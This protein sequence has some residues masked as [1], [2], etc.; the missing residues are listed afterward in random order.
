MKNILF[1]IVLLVG[2]VSE[3]QR[4][5]GSTTYGRRENRLLID[6][7]GG[8]PSDTIR[9]PTTP[10]NLQIYSWVAIK[11]GVG[12]RWDTTLL[13]WVAFSSA[14]SPTQLCNGFTTRIS[15]T[16][17]SGFDFAASEGSYN[18][19]CIPYNS[20]SATFRL[21]T[22]DDNYDRYDVFYADGTGV[23]VLKGIA[24]ELATIPSLEAGQLFIAWVRIPANAITP[25]ISYVDI[26][27]EN[28]EWTGSVGS[29]ATANFD[30]GSNVY[31]GSKAVDWSTVGNA[32]HLLF[33]NGSAIDLGDYDAISLFI[34]NKQVVASGANLF[35]RWYDTNT[36]VSNEVLIPI[37]K[38]TVGS[39][40]AISIPLSLFTIQNYNAN[41]LRIIYRHSSAATNTGFYI[42]NIFLESGLVLPG[43]PGND[44]SIVSNIPAITIQESNDNFTVSANGNSSQYIDG[45]GA[46]RT[47]NA[48]TAVGAFGSQASDPNGLKIVG[49]NI[50]GQPVTATEPGMTTPAMKASWDSVYTVENLSSL[51]D[52]VMTFIDA[53]RTGFKS[54]VEGANI[55]ITPTD[56]TLIIAASGGGAASYEAV[57]VGSNYSVAAGVTHVQ[58]TAGASG[59]TIT[60]PAASS[61]TGRMITIGGAL[62]NPTTISP[63]FVS[64]SVG[65]MYAIVSAGA[66]IDLISDGTD[67]IQVIRGTQMLPQ[68]YSLAVGEDIFDGFLNLNTIGQLHSP[69]FR[70]I[71]QGTGITV[72]N[73]GN[74]EL[75]IAATGGGGIDST[76]AS[77]GNQMSGD[78]VVF[79]GP[80]GTPG[81]FTNERTLNLNRNIMHWTNGVPAEA[82]GAYWQF[83]KR[84]FSPYQ[85]ISAD[86]VT[87]NNE[88]LS[89]NRPLSGLFARRTLYYTSG[90]RRVNESYGHYLGMT[91]NFSDSMAFHTA[92]GDYNQSVINEMRIKPRGTGRQVA[93]TGHTT[94]LHLKR[95]E[96]VA[97]SVSNFYMDGD[98]TNKLYLRGTGVGHSSYLIMFSGTTDTID[99]FIYY[100]PS[101]FV[102]GGAKILKSYVLAPTGATANEVDSSFFL[103]DTTARERSYH[104][105]NL[106]IGPSSSN[107]SSDYQLDLRGLSRFSGIADYASNIGSSYTARSFTDKNYVDSSIA[108]GGGGSDG[109]FAEN[110]LTFD[111]NRTHALAGNTLSINQGANSFLGIDPTAGSEASFLRAYN[112]TDDDNVS[113]FLAG[114]QNTQAD[115][116]IV[117]SFNNNVKLAGI[118]GQAD[119]TTATLIILAEDG[120]TFTGNILPV[121]DNSTDIGDATNSFQDGYFRILHL[122]GSTSGSPTIFSDALGNTALG[123]N[124]S[125]TGTI[126]FEQ[127]VFVRSDETLVN[128]N[129]DQ[130]L[131]SNTAHNTITI[132]ANTTYMFW[133]TFNLDHSTTSHSLAFGM[134]PTTATITNIAYNTLAQVSP[135]GTT[136]STQLMNRVIVTTTVAVNGAGANGQETVIVRG[137][138]TVGATGGTI[139]PQIKFS[140]DPTGTIL[141]KAGAEFHVYPVGN[142][143]FTEIGAWN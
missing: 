108:A 7:L 66:S 63:P 140:A 97:A 68:S 93:A 77:Q 71:K 6:S 116:T 107:W 11:D 114:T 137:W 75:E 124:L 96:G 94:A 69:V 27:K 10:D 99:N 59:V 33:T 90:I 110:D 26:Y 24:E 62:N 79:A 117:A 86:T 34:R 22:A 101:S 92:G 28:I 43:G 133:G 64:N 31:M 91:Y 35:A 49:V 18:I 30:N 16:Y 115:F 134:T 111:G 103:F 3:A 65:N 104:A 120:I 1:F 126:P 5:Q 135:I 80:I 142:N 83:T 15:I 102:G 73:T 76:L 42:D 123:T 37:N 14:A 25:A 85:L 13:R 88:S 12:Y 143:T 136:T 50:Y 78:T 52:S 132:Q 70:K 38:A 106:T 2:L 127:H 21:D 55:T 119:A 23:H 89:L 4:L 122:D 112:T 128:T 118:T 139:T 29:G 131:F 95:N 121:S 138:F 67:W 19:N 9:V 54:L 40:Q 100:Q 8:L 32:D 56:S 60:L 109:N 105:G 84:P 125:G 41:R 58:L 74:A 39:Y 51:G 113:T 48:V 61:N 46:L 98:G 20:D 130:D 82:G 57:V 129:A 45:T 53:A 72:T 87:V 44:V 17:I 47:F 36:P 81:I 141:L